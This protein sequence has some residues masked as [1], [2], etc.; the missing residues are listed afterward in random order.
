MVEQ[1]QKI[2][3]CAFLHKDNKV[4]IAK[5]AETKKFLPGK[6]ELPGGHV[7]FGEELEAGLK[8][9]FKE[10]FGVEITVDDPFF[11]FTYTNTDKQSHSVEIIYFATLKD[12][13]QQIK[14]NPNDHSEYKWLSESEIS[15]LPSN[16]HETQAI[17]KGFK[18]LK[19]SL[20]VAGDR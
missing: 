6:Y 7:E 14:L 8:R 2:T 1:I 17:V 4:F 11:A 18:L 5:R 15:L 3:A 12:E 16:D 10:E 13:T 9:E 20:P 19:K